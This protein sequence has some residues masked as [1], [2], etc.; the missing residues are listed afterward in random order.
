LKDLS[1]IDKLLELLEEEEFKIAHPEV[2]PEFI[3]NGGI[4]LQKWLLRPWHIMAR[5]QLK[6]NL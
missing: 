5:G 3:K 1:S 2:G 4:Y 6:E